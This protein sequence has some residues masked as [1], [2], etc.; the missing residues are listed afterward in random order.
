[1]HS[2]AVSSS[3]RAAEQ[4]S[5]MS[6]T[7]REAGQQIAR[8][9]RP[10]TPSWATAGGVVV[11]TQPK[12][13]PAQRKGAAAG[14]K[15]KAKRTATP[16]VDMKSETGVLG[17]T[18]LQRK[19]ANDG[20]LGKEDADLQRQA[21]LQRAARKEAAGRRSK[22]PA[23]SAATIAAAAAMTAGLPAAPGMV[24]ARKMKRETMY[25]DPEDYYEEDEVSEAN[26][27][28]EFEIN[29]G[30]D[31]TD[32]IEYDRTGKVKSRISSATM[33]PPAD[34]SDDDDDVIDTELDESYQEEDDDDD[35]DFSG[36]GGSSGWASFVEQDEVLEPTPAPRDIT[37]PR[38][39]KKGKKAAAAAALAAGPTRES[40][41]EAAINAAIL[42]S[43]RSPSQLLGRAALAAA[44]RA[45]ADE[46]RE[47]GLDELT[48][49][50][51]SSPAAQSLS[52][53]S[54]KITGDTSMSVQW[55]GNVGGAGIDFAEQEALLSAMF[56]PHQV[57]KLME[58]QHAVADAASD[59]KKKAGGRGHSE[60]K[61]H[62]KLRIIS[63]SAAGKG[64]LSSQGAQT[65]PM[66]DKVRQAI[67]NMIQS[68]AGCVNGLPEKSRWL[69]LFAGT[70]SVGL[71]ALSRGVGE[72]HF[73]EMDPWVT[74]TVLGKNIASCGFTRRATIHTTKAE[75]FLRRAIELPRFAGGAFDFISVCP[76]YLLVSYPELFDLL[77]RSPLVHQG[78]IVF[79]EYPKQLSHEVPQ[80][81]GPLTAVRDRKYGRTWIRVYAYSDAGS[82]GEESDSEL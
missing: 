49:R 16:Y 47:W 24:P 9:P 51:S 55:G 4:R 27:I 20:I 2:P 64:L 1:M 61:L 59:L 78:S 35:L 43:S 13:Q 14:V 45:D 23:L 75:D 80:T 28:P 12:A 41:A 52:K 70:G 60:H 29:M 50:T 19:L 18:L 37:P 36:D 42:S 8:H 46:A 34:D 68:Q 44:L 26:D 65:R 32:I 31:Y 3:S 39:G 57:K 69:D 66:M 11:Q 81:L 17:M 72:T 25:I 79:V 56:K 67:F 22:L 62:S 71:E 63:G 73:I 6:S 82:D 76:P 33:A 48:S 15:P 74:R 21:Q 10:Q 58:H 40:T 7:V 54:A 77:E 30:E 53:A 5:S 38:V